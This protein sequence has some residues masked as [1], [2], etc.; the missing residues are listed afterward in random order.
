MLK[1]K[2]LYLLV[3]FLFF[4]SCKKGELANPTDNSETF[5]IGSKTLM[6]YNSEGALVM[7]EGEIDES[8]FIASDSLE[9]Y[10]ESRCSSKLLGSTLVK[11]FNSSGVRLTFP[12]EESFKIY[13]STASSSD[14][15]FLA[16]YSLGSLT[17]NSPVFSE[18]VPPSPNRI[19]TTPGLFG[20]AFPLS[21]SVE[22][23][24][25]SGCINSLSSGT[26][27]QF[28]NNGITVS[29][30]ANSQTDIY[31]QTTDYK[32]DVSTCT[33][34]VTYVH[35][36]TLSDPPLLTNISPTSPTNETLTP[37]V[38]GTASSGAVTVGLYSDSGCSTELASGTPEEFLNPGLEITALQNSTIS[39]YAK[40]VNDQD[41]PSVCNYL[42][43]FTHDRVD[44]L[45]PAFGS[46]DPISPT[47]QTTSPLVSGVASADTNVI[48]FYSDITC[49]TLIGVG[50]R[51]DFT[52]GGVAVGVLSNNNTMIYGRAFDAAGNGSTCVEFTSYTHNTIAPEAPVFQS[53]SPAS[54]TNQT[55][56]PFILA[57]PSQRTV[58]VSFFSDDSCSA[59][60][61]SGTAQ[62][63]SDGEIQLTAQE[64]EITDV[65]AQARDFEGN[66]SECFSLASYEH[67]N[68]PSPEPEFFGTFPPSPSNFSTTPLIIGTA[69]NSISEV[70]IYSD[71]ACSNLLNSGTRAAYTSSGLAVTLQAN[72]VSTV[73]GKAIDKFGNE[74][75]CV[76]LTE[77]I[78]TNEKPIN[79]TYTEV[80][81]ESPNNV[82]TSPTIFGTSLQNPASVLPPNK[83]SF[84]DSASCVSKLGEGSPTDYES[85]S[86]VQLNVP[87]NSRSFVYARSVDAA[88]NRSD[89]TFMT[90]Y[91]H[92]SLVPAAP[93]F[94]SAAPASP[95]YSQDTFIF[96]FYGPSQDFMNRVSLDLYTDSSCSNSLASGDPS[97]IQSTG[98]PIT[99]NSNE[100]TAIY[101]KSVNEVGT[102]SSC[103]SLTN[104]RHYDQPLTNL[105][106]QL[107]T[108]GSVY[109]SW[110][111]DSVSKPTPSYTVERSDF[112]TGPFVVISSSKTG[113]T[114]TDYSVEEGKTYYYR[115]YATN[116][117]GRGQYNA[118][119]SI[120]INSSE[121]S[122]A[123]NLISTP[124]D[125][126]VNLVWNGFLENMEYKV[127]RSEQF[128]G[129]FDT[130]IHQTTGNSYTD[131][132]LINGNTYY[133]TVIASNPSSESVQSNVTSATPKQTPSGLS[134]FSLEILRNARECGG[135]IA[136]RFSWNA[137]SYFKSYEILRGDN[138]GTGSA[139]ASTGQNYYL[140]C[141][142]DSSGLSYYSARATWGVSAGPSSESIGFYPNAQVNLAAFSGDSEVVLT[143]NQPELPND[144]LN[145]DLMFDLYVS[146]DPDKEFQVLLTGATQSSF[147]H[148]VP[149]DSAYY[150]YV[151]AYVEEGSGEK[152][153]IGYPSEIMTARTAAGVSSPINLTLVNNVEN[154]GFSLTWSAPEFYNGF[155]IYSAENVSG[156][157]TEFDYVTNNFIN[158]MSASQGL[159]HYRVSSIWGSSEST[160]SN[161]VSYRSA[162]IENLQASSDENN[163]SLSWND[164]PDVQ[165]YVVYRDVDINGSYSTS[166]VVT[167]SS[168]TD[169]TADSGQGYYY[170]VKARFTDGTEGRL[171]DAV[172]AMRRGVSKP[173]GLSLT[174]TSAG[175]VKVSWAPV[176]AADTYS[177]LVSE[178]V[179]GP[180]T[181][182]D[183]TNVTT[184]NLSGLFIAREYFIKVVANIGAQ[185]HESDPESIF[186][187]GVPSPPTLTPG[188]NQVALTWPSTFVALN[189]DILRSSD[190]VN[191]SSVVAGFSGT[192]YVDLTATNDNLYFYKIRAHFPSSV[193]RVSL[194]SSS[195]TP[196][197][198]PLSPL[199]LVAEN[200]GSG[201]EVE[202]S[203]S[204]VDGVNRYNIY[205]STSP[206]SYGAPIRNTSSFLRV[207]ANGLTEGVKYYFSVKA[208]NGSVES[209]FSNEVVIV[210]ASKPE[211][212]NP[213]FLSETE[214]TVSWPASAS[215]Y[216]L[217]R[218][219][220]GFNFTLVASDLVGVSYVD[221]TVDPS[222]TYF[223]KYLTK[224]SSGDEI[225]FSELS[226]PVTLSIKPQVPQGFYAQSSGTSEVLLKW[227]KVTNVIAYQI[228]RST[229]QGGGHSLIATLDP[230]ELD[231]YDGSVTTGETYSY[232]VRSVSPS[233]R[234][235]D[236]STE[237]SVSL[238]AG[239]ENLSALDS[240]GQVDL[241]WDA[242]SGVSEYE[243]LRSEQSGG[244]YGKVGQSSTLLYSDAS[245]VSNKDYYYVVL[246]VLPDGSK[247]L[248]SNEALVSVSGYLSFQT[249]IEMTDSPIASDQ[250][251]DAVFYRTQTSFSPDDY[252]GV[253]SIQLEL[254]ANNS[255]TVDRVVVL[256]DSSDNV[257]G[258]VNIPSGTNQR[259]LFISGDL[260]LNSEADI[261]RLG[262]ERSTFDGQVQVLNAKLNINQVGASKTKIY[263]PLLGSNRPPSKFDGEIFIQ[264]TNQ[265]NYI[266]LTTANS[267]IREAEKLNKIVDYN[268]WEIETV[269]ST[270]GG[271]EGAL[272]FEN[273]TQSEMIPTTETVFTG[274]PLQ[275]A[276]T[277]IDEG[278]EHFST[279]NEGD[280]YKLKMKCYRFCS[281]GSVNIYK[282]GVWV[283][284]QNL[285]KLRLHK[286]VTSYHDLI[287]SDTIYSESRIDL[288]PDNFSQAK[289][290]FNVTATD[291]INSSAQIDLM[292]H[293]DSSGEVSLQPVPESS[294]TVDSD[295]KSS[296]TSLEFTPLLNQ[297]F[298]TRVGVPSGEVDLIQSKVIIDVGD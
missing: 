70:N 145:E 265:E 107:R 189:Y 199:N 229:T 176:F 47:N 238:L 97:L 12:F 31:A 280:I 294:L 271:A 182:S 85:P 208:L 113:N 286:R 137:Q 198:I 146:D 132:G 87:A 235:S 149:N 152:T 174:M 281:S 213:Q 207:V 195:V 282:A 180:Y 33:E 79:P 80:L 298:L 162:N 212:P 39:I 96:G 160:F 228:Y 240:G 119:V 236:A 131:Q 69:V 183:T 99:V 242:V 260:T 104:F 138:S 289:Y 37:R 200:N 255:D 109:L 218:S 187:Y 224:D 110:L 268:A 263:Y 139:F 267:F 42:A 211:K 17:P 253:D 74:S 297:K 129:P 46:V 57:A 34:L 144:L 76:Y 285:N 179:S 142:P 170:K 95:S 38:R 4:V 75:S 143:W 257:L 150:Y 122:P 53:F 204:K 40:S 56:E 27:E 148:S 128:G 50:S 248:L 232:V 154:P 227:T 250:L 62:E 245:V 73:Y 58:A 67:S 276:K 117:T 184:F 2:S 186:T 191:F 223:Y 105:N 296:Y 32:G 64:N 233:G 10:S 275:L 220:S 196:G 43:D 26:A 88:G 106:V 118:P 141:S 147:I 89:C 124:E 22:F 72:S 269:V 136:L 13:Y 49:S 206:G 23:F 120:T 44:P 159:W 135:T 266:D 222:K 11:D 194:S 192:N 28:L 295:Q 3:F 6:D 185:T 36:T 226:D 83:V 121:A 20:E 98:F 239:P 25:D 15:L 230:S 92:N 251:G 202:L 68:V 164:I 177:I 100:Q 166:F 169:S 193:S 203:W 116:V 272:I 9:F 21:S 217:Y 256:L 261:Y 78:H 178:D 234:P 247:T 24:S 19:S 231:Y 61:G 262:I 209:D 252:D 277:Y 172:S 243:I 111:P 18:V 14:C 93:V 63:L 52:G 163:V 84:Y 168:Y 219:E 270:D 279:E 8:L 60:I 216:D 158:V 153:F 288:N 291:D 259:T 81:P 125:G 140:N 94:T 221:S 157:F 108:D 7:F 127:Y 91:T 54:P 274:A 90:E 5:T 287:S 225:A 65:F 175:F 292:Y 254:V 214:V 112:S 201:T 102:E 181:L 48:R 165:D 264:S 237:V 16:D 30:P 258:S 35:S 161:V 123:A 155:Q 29:V 188:D 66:V 45:P 77:Y 126:Q 55:T 205:M 151:Q 167:Q 103:V 249:S 246:G 59:L 241:S 273:R 115:V 41:E 197:S 244:T 86:G 293:A 156:P 51:S 173:S 215:T 290:Y 133:Y 283:K 101:G 82:T 71:S 171:S 130:L 1:T 278:V 134:D 284:L 210:A 114:H 190:G